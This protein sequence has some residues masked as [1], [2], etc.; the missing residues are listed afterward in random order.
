MDETRNPT[1]DDT[2]STELLSKKDNPSLG[3]MLPAVADEKRVDAIAKGINLSDPSLS[4]TYGTETMQNISKF[5]DDLLGRVQAKD[6]GEIGQS[7]TN[8]MT[9]VKSFDVTR[10]GEK[11][12]FLANLP[13]IGSFFN[14]MENS[15]A[16]FKTLS[17]QVEVITD[18]L[19]KSMVGLLYDVEIME[20]LYQHN[21]NFH[22]D[23]SVF[24][25]AGKKKLEQART[26]DL[27]QLQEAAKASGNAMEAQKVRDFAEQ[28]NRF[29]RRL[30]DLELSRTITLQTAPQIRLIQSN[31]QTLAEKIQTSILT[32]IPI[33]K[34][35]MVLALS[36]QGQKNAA[37]LQKS[38]AD[39]TNDMLR[40]NAD[41]LQQS[42]IDTAREVE[43]SVVDIETLRDVHAKLISTI[44]E[45]MRIAQEGREKRLAAERELGEM[46][47]Q[48]KAKLTSLAGKKTQ[49]AIEAASGGKALPEGAPAGAGSGNP[50]GQA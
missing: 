12:G 25:D 31:N 5:A 47:N 44:E 11:P 9:D 7:L 20:K 46:E 3:E 41:L 36:L 29:E 40:K 10:I 39:T 32:T 22:N 8:L 24:I 33:W 30:H 38:V 50:E 23:L 1:I 2:L 21:K 14:K 15:L 34:S 49:D 4:I 28:I 37:L 17:E 26:V 16:K 35:Q 18:K 45:S 13:V 48:L 19:D 6:A 27:P 42:S 43:R